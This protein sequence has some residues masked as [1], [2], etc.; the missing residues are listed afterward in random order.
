MQQPDDALAG[1]RVLDCSTGRAGPLASMLLADFGAEVVKVEPP[2]GDPGRGEP[3]FAVWN[4]GKRSV[5]LDS[6]SDVERLACGA[7][8]VVTSAPAAITPERVNELNP[9]VVALHTPP[10]LGPVPWAGGRESDEL[11]TAWMGI[12]LRQA[13]FDGGPIDSIYPVVTT[14]QGI[15][16]AACAVAALVERERSGRGQIVTVSGEHGAM[17]AAAGALTFTHAALAEE[18]SARRRRTGGPGGSVPFY[19]TYQCGDGEWLFFAALTPRFT[20]LGFEVLGL[21]ELVDDPRLGGRGRAAMLQPEHSGWVTQTIAAKFLTAPRDEW[22]QRLR[23]AGCPSGAVLDREGWL[24]HQQIDATEMNVAVDD[25]VMPGVPL[26]L[27]RTPGRIRGPAPTLGSAATPRWDNRPTSPS[28]DDAPGPLAGVRVLDLGAIIAGPFA[29]SLLGELGA[30]VIK[31]E[32]LTGDSFRGPGFA[33]Y[34]K[35]QRGVALDLRHARGKAAFDDLVRHADIVVDNYRPGVLGRLGIEWDSLLGVNPNVISASITGFGDGG[36]FGNDAG[37]D[38]VLQAMSG[39]MKAQGG[40]SNPVFFTVPVND[41]AGSATLAF[42]ATL[43]LFH[44]ERTGAPQKVT[45]SLAAMSVL[46]QTEAL[47]RYPGRPAPQRGS[48]DH[49]GPSPLDRFYRTTDGWVRLQSTRERLLEAIGVDEG[50]D[51]EAAA[52]T[53]AAQ[54]TRAEALARLSRLGVPAVPART[55]RDIAADPAALAY[56]LLHP[57]PRPDRE[58][59]TAG[60]HAHFSRTMRSDTLVSPRLGQHTREVFEEAGYSAVEVDKLIAAGAA[61]APDD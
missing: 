32:P 36:P 35:G 52:A 28:G 26:R 53:W 58:G 60:R 57:D 42:G 33:A 44:R 12:P 9:A 56:E 41:V 7:D 25:V 24:D 43:A 3:G 15:W 10:T 11:I 6:G 55:V 46:L 61:C 47:V 5:V 14:I 23:A 54:L 37:F 59:C 22:L 13:S 34:N 45:T 17:V 49:V 20:Q 16:A 19:R 1:V 18:A 2:R 31:V 21:S 29:A 50:H 4:R 39:I 30:G 38:P 48:R 8:V 40:D 51:V 27:H